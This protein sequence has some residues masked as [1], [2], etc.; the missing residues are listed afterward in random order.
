MRKTAIY[1][2]KTSLKLAQTAVVG[3]ALLLATGCGY[4]KSTVTPVTAILSSITNSVCNSTN[5]NSTPFSGG[6]GSSV[7]PWII[8]GKTQFDYLSTHSAY[9]ADYFIQGA[10]VD[11]AGTSPGGIVGDGTTAFTGVYDGGSYKITDMDLDRCPAGHLDPDP[12]CLSYVGYFGRTVGGQIKNL[13][14]QPKLANKFRGVNFVGLIGYADQTVFTNCTWVIDPAGMNIW[15]YNW[16]GA[17]FGYLD[18]PQVF[19]FNGATFANITVTIPTD[20][21]TAAGIVSELRHATLKNFTASNITI[22]A[23]NSTS[24]GGG[25]VGLMVSNTTS[26][27]ALKDITLNNFSITN[28]GA[29]GYIGAFVGYY[30]QPR[31]V[32]A[33]P[34]NGICGP[35]GGICFQ[36]LHATNVTISS[37]T[38]GIWNRYQAGAIGQLDGNQLLGVDGTG[39]D[40]VTVTG[41]S[42]IEN[43]GSAGHDMGGVMGGSVNATLTR[44]SSAGSIVSG[45]ALGGVIGTLTS[46]TLTNAY[47][48]VSITGLNSNLGGIAGG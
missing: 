7:S 32:A 10:D 11:F 36:N 46:G 18:T 35:T 15:A 21:I 31:W 29:S 34:T 12:L 48:S 41:L 20:T 44:L 2:I 9:W 24:W 3:I 30:G 1:L 19:D 14:F 28:G 23:A 39:V 42:I 16:M 43:G 6:D 40:N 33:D 27:A 37:Q 5:Q 4:V 8:C 45:N 17:L 22:N 26:P 13:T 47:S 38:N 25:I